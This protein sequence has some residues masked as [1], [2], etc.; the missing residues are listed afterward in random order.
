MDIDLSR[1]NG[2]QD[3]DDGYLRK[4]IKILQKWD[5]SVPELWKETS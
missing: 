5:V 4:C 2:Y 3:Y 1:I